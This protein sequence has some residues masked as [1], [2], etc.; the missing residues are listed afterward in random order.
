MYLVKYYK[1]KEK[2][3]RKGKEIVNVREISAIQSDVCV[4]VADNHSN[5][6][7]GK[8]GHSPSPLRRRR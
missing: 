7:G 8:S 3:K 5:V 1:K 6:G 2:K 4:H